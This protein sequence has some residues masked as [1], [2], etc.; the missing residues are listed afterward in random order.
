MH[1]MLRFVT[2]S[3]LQNRLKVNLDAAHCL[4]RN[5]NQAYGKRILNFPCFPLGPGPEDSREN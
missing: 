4:I 3:K 2:A 5:T 1:P